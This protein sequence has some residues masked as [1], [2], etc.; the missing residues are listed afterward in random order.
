MS[1]SQNAPVVVR[2]RLSKVLAV[3]LRLGPS[4]GVRDETSEKTKFYEG[5]S[6]AERLV[7]IEEAGEILLY[8]GE[9]GAERLVRI[10]DDSGV[11]FLEGEKGQEFVVREENKDGTID[12]Y[13]GG[14]EGQRKARTVYPNGE[15]TVYYG[16]FGRKVRAEFP[17]G[18]IDRYE[19]GK[20]RERVVRTEYSRPTH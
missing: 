13:E 19:N 5:E 11:M 18:R 14:N 12:Y 1:F 17:D 16:I 4:T 8:E 20:G 9:R 15:K 3:G 6:G 2:D 7:R 10:E